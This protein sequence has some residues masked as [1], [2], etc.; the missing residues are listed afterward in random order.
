METIGLTESELLHIAK[1]HILMTR[2]DKSDPLLGT[3]QRTT[4]FLRTSDYLG[5][6][7]DGC[8]VVLSLSA[9]AGD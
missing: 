6:R 3:T 8:T 4:G 9:H 2:M 5:R 1:E 7:A